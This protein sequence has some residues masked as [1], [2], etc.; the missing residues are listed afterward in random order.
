MTF[1]V[2]E[3][4]RPIFIISPIFEGDVGSPTKQWSIFSPFCFIQSNIAAVPSSASPSS[5]PVIVIMTDPS[6]GLLFT[7]SIAA[8]TKAATPDFMSVAPRPYKNPSFTSAPNGS[9][10]QEERSP[11]GT[12][13]V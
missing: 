11:T 2:I 10:D 13:S 12:T 6:G 7:K 8:A 3:P 9:T 1:A 4:R 5:S